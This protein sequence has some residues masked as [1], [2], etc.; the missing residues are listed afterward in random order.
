MAG[1]AEETS[2]ASLVEPTHAVLTVDRLFGKRSRRQQGA[3]TLEPGAVLAPA[4][5]PTRADASVASLFGPD[6]DDDE[7]TVDSG[8]TV[9][10]GKR[11]VERDDAGDSVASDDDTTCS[12]VSGP[13]KVP[14]AGPAGRSEPLP[15]HACVRL[16][17]LPNCGVV[18][19]AR[20][21]RA[22]PRRL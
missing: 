7:S 21:A 17:D 16:S 20:N 9:H 22:P 4:P 18:M 1:R 15:S 2:D 12:T 11:A 13:T 19:T 8:A 3:E 10:V 14:R 6:A 5:T